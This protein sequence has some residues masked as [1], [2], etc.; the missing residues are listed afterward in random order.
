MQCIAIVKMIQYPQLLLHFRKSTI[1]FE[2]IFSENFEE[3]PSDKKVPTK[4]AALEK[5]RA[6]GL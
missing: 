2:R 6:E 5:I 1:F 3:L 4:G